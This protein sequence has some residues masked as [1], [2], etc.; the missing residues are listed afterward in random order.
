MMVAVDGVRR[1]PGVT[2]VK[3]ILSR[4]FGLALGRLAGWVREKIEA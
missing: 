2:D 1:L 3:L 4:P